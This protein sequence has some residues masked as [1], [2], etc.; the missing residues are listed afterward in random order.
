MFNYLFAAAVVGVA[1]S[2]TACK[3]RDFNTGSDIKSGA[4]SPENFLPFNALK[5]L[6]D[7]KT[8]PITSYPKHYEKL[9]FNIVKPDGNGLIP[10]ESDLVFYSS[11]KDWFGSKTIDVEIRPTGQP[12][13]AVAGGIG[14]AN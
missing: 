13:T 1:L 7:P 12:G 3:Q 10:V 9:G 4:K 14:K 8:E 2:H 6:E 11:M 5:M